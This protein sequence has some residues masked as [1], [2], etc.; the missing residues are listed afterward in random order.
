MSTVRLRKLAGDLSDAEAVRVPAAL[1]LTSVP[2]ERP[3]R[4][5]PAFPL[6]LSPCHALDPLRTPGV[7]VHACCSD[8]DMGPD[9][10][11][12]SNY[13]HRPPCWP[14]E[15]AQ[16]VCFREA[17]PLARLTL[18]ERARRGADGAW[19]K[20]PTTRKKGEGRKSDPTDLPEEHSPEAALRSQNYALRFSGSM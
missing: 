15:P 7:F 14:R 1:K 2:D 9:S 8:A 16:G 3:T 19:D 6:Y 13:G 11:R 4:D 5:V 17:R 18:Q 10:L 20:A 12:E